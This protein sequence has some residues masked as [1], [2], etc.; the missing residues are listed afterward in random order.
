MTKKSKKNTTYTKIV[1]FFLFLTIVAIFTVM[2]FALAKVTIKIYGKVDNKIEEVLIEMESENVLEKKEDSILGKIIKTEFDLETSIPSNQ[3]TV[4]SEKAGGYVIIYNNY[5][6]NQILIATTR[7]LTPDNKLYRITE[8]I[9]IPAGEQVKVWAEA[10]Q[11]GEEYNI[12][13]TSFIIPG[14]WEGL[15]DKIYAESKD[16][17]NMQGV[18]K[19]LVSQESIN[20]AQKNIKEQAEI[21][22]LKTINEKLSNN[23]KIDN[24]NLFMKFETLESSNIN[25]E[26]E[27][28]IL[29]QH[30]TAY[31]LVFSPDTLK[32]ISETKFVQG[33]PDDQSLIKFFD[34][35]FNYEIVDINPEK[36]TAVLSVSLQA[37]INSKEG[38]WDIEKNKLIGLTQ[39]D[40]EKYLKGLKIEKYEISFFPI[41]VTKAPSLEDHI[42]IK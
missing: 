26:S 29:K 40:I 25:E 16:G 30:I 9:N 32:E 41:W 35:A 20:Q 36:E 11:L 19:Y 21:Q 33:L 8:R 2:H 28:T 38:S 1:G 23:L 37:D 6:Q 12:P 4:L 27:T 10:D 22:A 18:P 7:L 39:E 34:D 15:Q 31:G 42:I 13:P 3:E 17:M 14:L 5:S 24:R